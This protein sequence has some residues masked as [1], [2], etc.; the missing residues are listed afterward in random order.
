MS[1]SA[2][3]HGSVK[4]DKRLRHNRCKLE[5]VAFRYFREPF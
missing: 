5:P 2:M 3:R 4:L 1:H